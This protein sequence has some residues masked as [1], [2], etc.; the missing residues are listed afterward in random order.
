MAGDRSQQEDRDPYEHRSGEPDRDEAAISI[1]GTRAG[2]IEART[3]MLTTK[4][5]AV[6]AADVAAASPR[7]HPSRGD[8]PVAVAIASTGRTRRARRPAKNAASWLTMTVTAIAAATGQTSRCV[9]K[10]PGSSPRLLMAPARISATHRPGH[11]PSAAPA[12]VTQRISRAKSFLTCRG[13]AP[14]ARSRATSLSRCWTN[15][16]IMPASTRAA[17]KSASP[18]REPLIAINRRL[19]SAASR[20]STRPRSTPVRTSARS[21]TTLSRRAA[22]SSI[23]AV[24][25]ISTTRASTCSDDP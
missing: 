20:N 8:D 15:S 19:A 13:C 10:V 3:D 12:K 11:T 9:S 24:G 18:P 21:P 1:A 16:A 14:I 22:T 25:S 4:S 5:A 17:T 2:A 6:P 23:R 7:S